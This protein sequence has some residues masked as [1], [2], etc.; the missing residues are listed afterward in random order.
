MNETKLIS[1]DHAS[2]K[3]NWLESPIMEFWN[4]NVTFNQDVCWKMKKRFMSGI[5]MKQWTDSIYRSIRCFLRIILFVLVAYLLPERNSR[6]PHL[7]GIIMRRSLCAIKSINV[8]EWRHPLYRHNIAINICLS[9]RT[10]DSLC[11]S[12]IVAD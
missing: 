2:I 6:D 4:V 7:N 12:C 9:P 11:N 5:L 1:D 8:H 3:Y 10:N